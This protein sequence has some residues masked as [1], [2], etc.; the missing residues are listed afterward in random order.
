MKKEELKASKYGWRGMVK[1]EA[2]LPEDEPEETEDAKK[3][4][5]KKARTKAKKAVKIIVGVDEKVYEKR[6]DWLDLL[7]WSIRRRRSWPESRITKINQSRKEK[8]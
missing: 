1:T 3:E 7:G 5:N 8:K 2:V 6:R 4:I